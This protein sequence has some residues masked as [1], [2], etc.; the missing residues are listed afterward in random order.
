[1]RAWY[2]A[3]CANADAGGAASDLRWEQERFLTS[4]LIA[5]GM[6]RYAQQLRNLGIISLRGLLATDEAE[7]R[8]SGVKRAHLSRVLLPALTALRAIIS[9]I[10]RQAT[11]LWN[12]EASAEATEMRRN[13]F[14]AGLEAGLA[15]DRYAAEVAAGNDEVEAR[16]RRAVTVTAAES[17]AIKSQPDA[18]PMSPSAR[19][20]ALMSPGDAGE[21]PPHV[22][23][24][25]T[26]TA[27]ASL[28]SMAKSALSP[29][30]RAKAIG[31][32]PIAL[33]IG[34][35]DG[36]IAAA[37]NYAETKRS[38]VER[39]R[40]MGRISRAHLCPTSHQN[41][42]RSYIAVLCGEV[43]NKLGV[44]GVKLLDE[45]QAQVREGHGGDIRGFVGTGNKGNGGD[46]LFT[47]GETKI[48]RAHV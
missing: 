23:E 48:G 36:D 4:F 29:A 26:P 24:S 42:A 45:H 35:M 22:I 16:I 33:R 25:W 10:S 9:E 7:L 43:R 40:F 3:L 12:S 21:L 14:L 31:V 6:E 41:Q 11:P 2:E 47:A 46:V 27:I 1:V 17:S 37:A 19:Q 13:L 34:T 5:L 32:S 8:T 15:E 38:E 18:K 30:T 20:A 28:S 44:T 39:R